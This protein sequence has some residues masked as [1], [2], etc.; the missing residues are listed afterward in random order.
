[1]KTK[2]PRVQ[3]ISEP[4]ALD[5]KQWRACAIDPRA[6]GGMFSGGYAATDVENGV[7]VVSVC[8]PLD[9]HQA[10]WLDSYD[11]IVCRVEDALADPDARAVVMCFDSPGGDASGVEESH[12]TIKALGAKYGK[13]IFAYSNEACYS[14]AYWLACAAE[15]IW[16]PPTGGVGS[17]GV[18][19]EAMDVTAANAIH[20]V[21]IELVTT[22]KHKADGHPDRPL[23][24]DILARVQERVNKLGGIFFASV[25]ESRD[26]KPDAV[27]SLQAGTFL[28]DD[29]VSEGLADGVAGWDQFLENVRAAV[30]VDS[31][32]VRAT[33]TRTSMAQKLLQLTAAVTAAQ[34]A[35]AAA[36]TDEE[37]GACATKLA[38]AIDAK[39][40]YSK[41]TRT[42]ELEED[43]GADD[44]DDDDDDDDDRKS[45]APPPPKSDEEEDE[46]SEDESSDEDAEDESSEDEAKARA[47]ALKALG[48]KG[49]D[50]AATLYDA[51][52]A[53]T[54][55]RDV[56]EAL[57]ALEGVSARLGNAKKL[58]ARIAK[59][60]STERRDRVSLMLSK[61]SASG[62]ITPAQVEPLRAQG[63]KDPKWLKGYLAQIPKSVRTV[64]DGA[65]A[66]RAPEGEQATL[67]IETMTPAVRE[68]YENSARAAGVT[69]DEFLAKARTTAA[70]MAPVSRPTH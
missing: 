6:F 32:K 58:E 18:I 4:R 34:T 30:G 53:L 16:L 19:A 69:L 63:M 54:G 37:R 5:A 8:G 14:A 42:D 56:R 28:G 66:P 61:A 62:K 40:K 21:R 3:A 70:R 41:R 17:V 60:E 29:A 27:E 67:A 38:A 12:R 59:L 2:R 35:L 23:T 43:D 51:V 10:W 36:K 47:K 22:G 31:G 9:H 48:S 39:V 7:A 20:G 45:S 49:T 24:D 25:A 26:L 13:R 15:E 50:V 1:M 57:G 52:V 55:K 44:E 11:S 65:L 46:D 68:M 64:E 33:T